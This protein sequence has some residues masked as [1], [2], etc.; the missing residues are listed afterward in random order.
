VSIEIAPQHRGLR[1]QEAR[2]RRSG[3]R[4]RSPPP[5]L[6]NHLEETLFPS[7]S[8]ITIAVAIVLGLSTRCAFFGERPACSLTARAT[9]KVDSAVLGASRTRSRMPGSSPRGL[10]LDGQRRPRCG[11][12]TTHTQNKP[13]TPSTGRL[14]TDRKTPI[15]PRPPTCC[16]IRPGGSPRLA[17]PHV[18][19]LDLGVA[20]IFLA[21]RWICARRTPRAERAS[22]GTLTRSCAKRTCVRRIAREGGR[23]HR[24]PLRDAETAT[25]ARAIIGEQIP[26]L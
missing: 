5:S 23:Q 8:T 3:P 26:D 20:C 4:A 6:P 13:R 17:A 25:E 16:P 18:P 10:F 2:S 15:T 1:L 7:G 22:P 24:D 9:M 14:E 19:R 12:P 11:S 21:G